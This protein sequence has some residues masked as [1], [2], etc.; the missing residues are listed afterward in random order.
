MKLIHAVRIAAPV[1]GLACSGGASDLTVG[2]YN[3]GPI[4][5]ICQ[6]LEQAG[7]IQVHLLDTLDAET[8]F[9]HDAIILG[10]L[11]GLPTRS[12]RDDLQV[13]AE[14]GGGVM[15]CHDS[16]GYRGWDEPLFPS[17][18]RGAGQS[19]EDTVWISKAAHPVIENLPEQF[20][21]MYMD[22]I[23]VAPRA[24]GDNAH[25]RQGWAACGRVRPGERGAHHWLRVIARVGLCPGRACAKTVG[26]SGKAISRAGRAMAR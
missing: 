19:T 23:L 8:L 1:F 20:D 11:K 26:R 9:N 13:Y 15:L 7:G 5:G 4:R 14:C 25:S 6:A 10:S 17:L 2:I 18:F 16:V 21:P 12:W 22:H 24:R 3:S